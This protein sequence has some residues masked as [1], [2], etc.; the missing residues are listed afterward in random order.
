MVEGEEAVLR[1]ENCCSMAVEELLQV[2][3][4]V[5]M[6]GLVRLMVEAEAEEWVQILLEEVEELEQMMAEV[7]DGVQKTEAEA[8]VDLEQMMMAGVGPAELLQA[9]EVEE[10]E[11][12]TAGLAGL[13][14][15]LAMLYAIQEGELEV[16]C[17]WE[18]VVHELMLKMQALVQ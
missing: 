1:V 13:E 12:Q 6:E 5:E 9:E 16:S 17:L 18:E 14:E 10:L 4:A 2:V 8:V 3:A 11:L 7:E 15:D